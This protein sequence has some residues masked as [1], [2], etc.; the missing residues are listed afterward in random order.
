VHLH[1]VS[2]RRRTQQGTTSLELPANTV[3]FRQGD[4]SDSGIYIVVEGSLGIYLQDEG[5]SGAPEGPP[6]LTNLLHE[7]ESVGDVDVVDAARRAVSAIAQAGGAR[8]VVVSRPLF[9]SFVAR[10][11][12][13]L[14]TYL[15]QAL[16]RLWRVAH[17]VLA[18]FLGLP[19][20]VQERADGGGAGGDA[21][22]PEAFAPD[23]PLASLGAGGAHG[24]ALAAAGRRVSLSPG[25]PLYTERA[26]AG[27]L[28]VLLSGATRADAVP[29]PAGQGVSPPP[30]RAPALL[31]AAAFLTRTPRRETVR[32]DA[33]APAVL[34]AFGPD[35]LETLLHAAP[36]A[37]VALLLVAASALAPIIRRFIGL[38]LNRVW[39]SAGDAAFERNAPASSLY[40]LISGRVRLM[41]G[42]NGTSATSSALSSSASPGSDPYAYGADGSASMSAYAEEAGRGDTIG[43]AS[44][45]AGG[46]YDATAL[47]VRDSELVRMSR[48]AFELITARSPAAAARLLEAMARKLTRDAR[49]GGSTPGGGS[50]GRRPDLV[51]ICILPA[52]GAGV[53]PGAPAAAAGALAS[54][55]ASALSRFGPTLALDRPGAAARFADGT[56]ARLSSRFYRSKLTGWMAQQEESYR[57]ILLLAEPRASA[58]SGVCV[59]QADCVLVVGRAGDPPAPGA[60][61]ASLL[62]RGARGARG[63]CRG[64]IEL[65][66]LHGA[67][68]GMGDGGGLGGGLGGAVGPL[69]SVALPAPRGTAAWLDGRP[70]CRAHHHARA[71]SALDAARIARHLAG[72][73]VGV[74][75]CGSGARG[76][77]H[78]GAL[79]ALCDAGVPIDVVGGTSQGALV[80]AAFARGASTRNL[81]RRCAAFGA[82]SGSARQL[83]ADA[84][85]PLLSFFAGWGLEGNIRAALGDAAIEDLWLRF[86]C[87]STNLTR[88]SLAV[89]ERG[90]ASRYVRAAQSVLGLLPPVADA[91]ELLV[92]GGYL[93]NVRCVFFCAHHIMCAMRFGAHA[94]VCVFDVFFPPQFPV[95]VMHERMGCDTVIVVDVDDREARVCD[96]RAMMALHH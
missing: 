6:L 48:A 92:D 59:S 40:I 33:S 75:L 5:P 70:L 11:P 47:C 17:F 96:K 93:N 26:P 62:W 3:L 58:W 76:L 19:R 37:F 83:V 69:P 13:S 80:A 67:G 32:A 63:A 31:G 42:G 4:P 1:Y 50:Y 39:L 55:L 45:L 43:E 20:S 73:A 30:L 8:L 86:F 2:L 22:P 81:L 77:A 95:D 72:R 27:C 90:P 85:L 21:A 89:H 60:A 84:T 54:A 12:R 14:H 91:G 64:R 65:A 41:R 38:G 35:E 82:L 88:G 10:H 16:A 66:L 74:L 61:E 46:A 87:V 71:G 51:T 28:Y 25:E 34:L 44:L 78:L 68:A 36:D 9:L 53:A 24:A 56:V 94:N 29:W 49:P 23:G 79:R 52:E 57:F 18:D 15:T 7:G